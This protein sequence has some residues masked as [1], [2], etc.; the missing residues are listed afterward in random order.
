VRPERETQQAKTRDRAIDMF[1]KQHAIMET[2]EAIMETKQA[3]P[4][5]TQTPIP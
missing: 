2:H 1:K 4:Y 3:I 5:K